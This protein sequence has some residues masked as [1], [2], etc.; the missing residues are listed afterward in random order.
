MLT[1]DFLESKRHK[2]G[3]RKA[4]TSQDGPAAPKVDGSTDQSRMV[5]TTDEFEPATVVNRVFSVALMQTYLFYQLDALFYL[6]GFQTAADLFTNSAGEPCSVEQ[7]LEIYK[8]AHAWSL[9]QIRFLALDH[10]RRRIY[11][12]GKGPVNVE[13]VVGLVCT[14]TTALVSTLQHIF[15]TSS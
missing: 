12:N 3:R 5:I 4:Q 7:E 14:S 2:V 9:D 8:L 13:C 1:Q 15:H 10:L 11:G 6:H